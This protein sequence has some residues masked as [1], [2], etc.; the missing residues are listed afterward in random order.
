MLRRSSRWLPRA[1]V[2]VGATALLLGLLP[3][4]A[5]AHRD[6]CHRWHSCPSDSG[7]YTCGDLGYY[8]YCGGT[9]GGSLAESVDVTAPKRP[10]VVRPRAGRGGRVSLTVTAEQG[11]RIEVAETDEYGLASGTVAKATATG[12]A[13]TI[14]FKADNGSHAYTVT[15]T[16]AAGNTSDESADVTVDVDADAPDVTGFSIA[17]PD[18]TTA[19]ARVSFSSEAGAAYELTVSGRKERLN[20]TVGDDGEVS[21]AALV[22]PDGGYTARIAVTDE[23]G[24]VGRAEQKLRVSLG[25]LAPK[26]AADREPG[27]GRVRFT[28]TAPPRSK[29]RLAVGDAT[30]Q[31][32]TTDADGR[33][34]IGAQLPDGS[35]PAPV[36]TV[37]DPFGRSGRASGPKLVVDTT[38][39]AL[40]VTSDAERAAHGDLALTVTTEPHT[41]IAVSY[42]SGTHAGL[43]SSGHASTVTRALSPGTYRVTVTATDAYGNATTKRLKIA[44]DDQPT[45]GEWLVLLLKAILVS[46]LIVAAGYVYHRTRPARE[47][48][49]ARR[50]AERYARELRSWEQEHER[51]VELADFAA[52]LGDDERSVGGWLAAW[53]KR[54]RDESV[55]WVTDADMVQP[56][57]NG[58]DIS[59]R[60]SGTLVVTG[61][62]VLFVGGTRREWLFSKLVHV[63]HSGQDVTWMRVTNRTNVSGVRY[64][65][66]PEKTRITIESAIAEAPAGE[67]RELGTGRGPV[68]ARLR[69]A[70]TAHDRQRP[71]SPEPPP[72]VS[73]ARVGVINR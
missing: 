15:A 42:G 64:R 5:E 23:A 26:V 60:D 53:G 72:A 9:G 43:I 62:R 57:T 49:R 69:Q 20:G 68:L 2:T 45:A 71:S 30:D 52:E 48:G 25:E 46:A 3:A 63:E 44:V 40:K 67:A 14:T 35:Y 11:A 27:S 33:A 12:G 17:G 61:Q 32:F 18:A 65:R 73:P 6:G 21:D 38:A 1:G 28:V 70:I 19:T 24:N 22:L 37:T 8:T 29:G 4:T 36:V 66:E 10:K 7:S 59:V 47:A 50:A 54:K 34:E 58:L 39:P 55:W 31:A 41:K 56:G 16:D 13:Q 51:L